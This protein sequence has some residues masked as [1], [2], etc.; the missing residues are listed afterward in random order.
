MS[1]YVASSATALWWI[2]DLVFLA[3]IVPVVVIILNSVLRPAIEIVKYAD[4]IA[5]HGA[6]LASE[7]DGMSVLE[8]TPDL[9]RE[10]RESLERYGEAVEGVDREQIR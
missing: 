7:L 4:D 2:G 9:V 5:E 3:V 8:R 6:I 10:V 1:F